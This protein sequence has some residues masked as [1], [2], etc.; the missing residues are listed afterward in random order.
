MRERPAGETLTPAE[1]LSFR[2][3][4]LLTV[5]SALAAVFLG[6]GVMAWFATSAWLNRYHRDLLLQEAREI[7]SH[8]LTP[9]DSLDVSRY[10]W[11]EPHHRFADTRIDPYFVQ[12][13]DTTGRLLRA[14]DNIRSFPPGSYPAHRLPLVP[15][16]SSSFWP[17]SRIR[18]DAG[19]LYAE[20]YP[21]RNPSGTLRAYL[22]IT[23]FDPGIAGWL[24]QV[25]LLLGVGL[26]GLLLGLGLLVWGIAGRVLRPLESITAATAD[27]SAANLSRR[28]PIPADA[29]RETAQ[30]AST[31]NTLL[32]RLQQAFEE[33]RRFTADAAHELQTPLTILQGHIEV[34]LRR[35]RPVEAYRQTLHVL[36]GEVTHLIM[37]VRSL[38]TLARLDRTGA[39]LPSLPVDLTAVAAE[40]AE[41]LRPAADARG[42]ALVLDAST[43]VRVPG[44]ADLLHKLVRNLLDNAVKYT[45]SG[46][47]TLRVRCDAGR[48]VLCVEDT[49]PGIPEAVRGRVTDRFF[50][51]APPDVPG[52]GLGLALVDQI[53]RWHG[54]TL[55][56]TCPPSG[57]THACVT[58]PLLEDEAHTPAR[59]PAPVSES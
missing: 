37:T 33:T 30:L 28:I 34:A 38:L 50:R 4:L 25:A 11:Y 23:R 26:G 13:F 45:P 40:V 44:Q 58:L 48:A 39:S 55:S 31:L 41:T 29:D 52:S 18:T 8:I 2:H 16:T 46:T 43:P 54:G 3:R 5:G 42:L 12:V 17:L 35:E 27:L 53:A 20:V 14:S 21:V 49:G 24:R 10:A 15:R 19:L 57:G 51:A 59:D 36:Q 56:F 22:Q 6:I 7:A 1:R 32:D 47:V 9:D